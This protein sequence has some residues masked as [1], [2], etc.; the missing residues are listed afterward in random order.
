MLRLSGDDCLT[1]LPG[2]E[3]LCDEGHGYQEKLG[4]HRAISQPSADCSWP[5]DNILGAAA[6]GFDLYAC[7]VTQCLQQESSMQI[8]ALSSDL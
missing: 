5:A 1:T 7:S 3:A 4:W 6:E 8:P 2:A